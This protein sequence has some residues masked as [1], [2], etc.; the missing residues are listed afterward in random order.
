MFAVFAMMQEVVDT[1]MK[2]ADLVVKRAYCFADA[3]I[4]ER[5]VSLR[6][7][8]SPTPGDQV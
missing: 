6:Q 8:K 4:K 1:S 3:M 5:R 7:E 2:D